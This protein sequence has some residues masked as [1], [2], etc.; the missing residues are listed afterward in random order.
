MPLI[1]FEGID[2]CG[3]STQIL[4]LKEY[5]E[6]KG[7]KCSVFREP[8][9]T[10]IGEEIRKILLDNADSEMDP[11]TEFLLFAASRAQL[12]S[13]EIKPRIRDEFVILD[14]YV[15]SSVAYQGFARGLGKKIVTFINEFATDLIYPDLTFYIE[16]DEKI[17]EE[18]KKEKK[19]RIESEGIE[20]IKKVIEG[21]NQISNS[22]RFVKIDGRMEQDQLFRVIIEKIKDH[23]KV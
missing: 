16:I 5:F 21:Y 12:V 19:D 4:M 10:K 2:G 11:K 6:K 15:D 1:T 3:K 18:R 20:F 13:Q 9:G 17:F 23:F 22:S 8:G 7:I 14:R